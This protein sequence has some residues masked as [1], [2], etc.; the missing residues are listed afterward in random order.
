MQFLIGKILLT[1]I[2]CHIKVILLNSQNELMRKN[3]IFYKTI[4][5]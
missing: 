4:N 5:I 3:I 2:V 1:K